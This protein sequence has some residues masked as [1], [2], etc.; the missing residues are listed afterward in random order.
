MLYQNSA[1]HSIKMLCIAAEGAFIYREMMRECNNRARN[2]DDSS[3]I[4]VSITQ[5]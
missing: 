2:V 4:G 5:K 1:T 3:V